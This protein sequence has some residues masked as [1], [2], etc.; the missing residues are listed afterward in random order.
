MGLKKMNGDW[1]RISKAQNGWYPSFI[2]GTQRHHNIY[3]T[4][5]SPT[6]YFAPYQTS[7]IPQTWY[8]QDGP[9]VIMHQDVTPLRGGKCQGFP[10]P[11]PINPQSLAFLLS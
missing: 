3:P 5:I 9:Q 6:S 10:N 2:T 7:P 1:L 11:M 4:S 8:L